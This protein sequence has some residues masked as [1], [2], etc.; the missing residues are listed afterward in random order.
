MI[1]IP[2]L[3][4]KNK[5]VITSEKLA[6]L[7][8]VDLSIINNNTL[9][10]C[11]EADKHYYYIGGEE[12][13]AFYRENCFYIIP[14]GESCV[15]LWAEKG[16]LMQARLINSDEAWKGYEMLTDFYFHYP[17]QETPVEIKGAVKNN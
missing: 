14:S 7:Y 15:F 12:L 9:E 6:E 16:A 8:K 1:I 17:Y 10:K 4:Y 3:E 11:F 2:K 5:K 13:I